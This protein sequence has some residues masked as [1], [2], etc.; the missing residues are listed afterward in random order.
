MRYLRGSQAMLSPARR[1]VVKGCCI[2]ND[3][4]LE[5]GRLHPNLSRS[6]LYEVFVWIDNSNSLVRSIVQIPAQL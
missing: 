5:C 1:I 6:R 4:V 3:V 2:L